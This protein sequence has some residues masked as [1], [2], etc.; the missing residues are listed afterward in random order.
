MLM[1]SLLHLK[2]AYPALAK[3]KFAAS[4]C[5]SCLAHIRDKQQ[6]SSKALQDKDKSGTVPEIPG[7][8]DSI[9]AADTELYSHTIIQLHHRIKLTTL[10]MHTPLWLHA[11]PLLRTCTQV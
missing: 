5:D 4:S 8:L 10:H 6:A 11:V 9:Y 1:L 2:L 7:Q 3:I